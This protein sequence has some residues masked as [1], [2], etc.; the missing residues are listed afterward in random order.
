MGVTTGSNDPSAS[1]I[2]DAMHLMSN[3]SNR[4][5]VSAQ[6]QARAQGDPAIA[7]EIQACIGVL[8]DD[9]ARLR[10]LLWALRSR[11]PG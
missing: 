11:R 6:L 5:V 4:L 8:L 10:A 1:D 9:F 7:E 3:A 2:V